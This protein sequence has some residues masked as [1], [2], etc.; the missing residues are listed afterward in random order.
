MDRVMTGEM[1]G[2]DLISGIVVQLHNRAMVL[3]EKHSLTMLAA[4]RLRNVRQPG[5]T[6]LFDTGVGDSIG[7]SYGEIDGPAGTAV[8][9]RTL[10]IAYGNYANYRQSA[11]LPT[12]DRRRFSGGRFVF[13]GSR[14]SNLKS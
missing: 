9:A 6:V 4:Q 10:S 8:L 1:R 2:H 11:G 13:Y 5:K 14:C 12:R 3:Q 7:L